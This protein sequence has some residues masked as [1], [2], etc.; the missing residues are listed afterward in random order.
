MPNVKTV[1]N[2]K[3][4][5]MRFGLFLTPSYFHESLA[6][7]TEG[8]DA[9]GATAMSMVDSAASSK[10]KG[11]LGGQDAS[12][13]AGWSHKIEQTLD[14]TKAIHFLPQDSDW[15][16]GV[17]PQA[18]EHSCTRGHCLERALRH[19]YTQATRGDLNDPKNVMV[20]ETGFTDADAIRLLIGL[21]GDLVQPLHVGF[22]STDFGRNIMVRVPDRPGFPSSIISL[23]DLWDDKLIHQSIN[24]PYNPSAWWSGWTHIRSLN[25]SIVQAEKDRWGQKGIDSIEDWVKDSAEFACNHIY[26]NPVT[27]ERFDLNQRADNPILIQPDVYNIWERDMKERI[28]IGGVRLGLLLNGILASKDTPAAS[29]L[30]RGSAVNDPA[31]N[32]AS[33]IIETFDD[34]DDRGE[35]AASSRGRKA[36]VVG[37]NAGF[38]NAG[39]L[40]AVVLIVL[41]AYKAGATSSAAAYH[42]TKTQIVE[43]VGP[44]A[45]ALNSHRD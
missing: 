44:N 15:A 25:P 8:H 16:C 37:Y 27:K 29:K 20:D 28:L 7:N 33:D 10:L 4:S 21:M 38:V 31:S 35:H 42:G 3:N 34:L 9:I 6:W 36:P 45:K 24:N 19:F 23:Y 40:F 11:I 14:W 13:V 1:R 30:R 43:M 2:S 12:E 22:K 17:S 5:G 32:T 26:T 18:A 39:I 41:I